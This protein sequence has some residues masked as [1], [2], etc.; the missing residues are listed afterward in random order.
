[1]LFYLK[2]SKKFPHVLYWEGT[3]YLEI[4]NLTHASRYKIPHILKKVSVRT[5]PFGL[6][7]ES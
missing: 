3:F 4:S 2:H 1:M 6:L 7:V 5:K